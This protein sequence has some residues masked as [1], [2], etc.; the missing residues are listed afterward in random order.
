MKYGSKY[1]LNI[2]HIVLKTSNVL[3]AKNHLA[4]FCLYTVKF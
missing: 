4:M 2:Q 1:S 3:K